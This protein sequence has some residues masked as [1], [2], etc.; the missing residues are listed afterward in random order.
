MKL[1]YVWLSLA[2]LGLAACEQDAAPTAPVRPLDTVQADADV[3]TS[4]PQNNI[5]LGNVL[6]GAVL[7]RE[8]GINLVCAGKQ[9]VDL[10]QSVR[11]I[12]APGQSAVPAGSVS[13]TTAQT[14]AVQAAWPDDTNGGGTTNCGSPAP[15][16]LATTT[17]STVTLTAPTTPGSYTYVVT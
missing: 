17:Q 11:F 13:A 8:V 14:G 1:G 6:P 7:T 4:G 2:L 5:S 3:V 16:P 15:A 12:Y 9:H 10:N